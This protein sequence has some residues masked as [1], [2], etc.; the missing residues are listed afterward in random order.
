MYCGMIDL[1][2]VPFLRDQSRTI[3]PFSL[4]PLPP[5]LVRALFDEPSHPIRVNTW[6]LICLGLLALRLPRIPWQSFSQDTRNIPACKTS[7]EVYQVAS[8]VLIRT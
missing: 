5:P 7:G 1:V 8:L 6:L 4:L 2:N 3:F